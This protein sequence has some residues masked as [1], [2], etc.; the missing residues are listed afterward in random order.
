MRHRYLRLQ[1]LRLLHSSN[2][3]PVAP[4]ARFSGEDDDKHCYPQTLQ[5]IEEVPLPKAERRGNHQRKRR[6]LL[7]NSVIG[8]SG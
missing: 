5:V 1:T 2:R 7:A 3:S 8:L 4:T 6:L